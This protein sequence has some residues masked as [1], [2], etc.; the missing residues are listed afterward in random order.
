MNNPTPPLIN[1]DIT[2]DSVYAS[3][4]SIGQTIGPYTDWKL[5]VRACDQGVFFPPPL[6]GLTI[7]DGVNIEEG[8]RVLLTDS[9][10]G[11]SGIWT[12]STGLWQLTNDCP[13]GSIATGYSIYVLEGVSNGKKIFYCV[14]PGGVVG[15]DSLEFLSITTNEFID[16]LPSS[17]IYIGNASNK[18]TPQT[19]SGDATLSNTGVLTLAN[20][21]V[22]AGI[23]EPATLTINSK[24]LVTNGLSSIGGSN[25]NV[26]FNNS[27]ALGGNSN[28]TFDGTNVT[29][30][31]ALTSG[32]IFNGNYLQLS[33]TYNLDVPTT[34]QSL[35]PTGTIT[36]SQG[37]L[38]FTNAANVLLPQVSYAVQVT[39]SLNITARN[40]IFKI[41]YRDTYDGMPEVYVLNYVSAGVSST[42]INLMFINNDTTNNCTGVIRVAFLL[43]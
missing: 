25:G 32:G 33:S 34:I 30:F 23:Y 15:L 24:G 29:I 35:T 1:S 6:I 39:F 19:V 27:G 26:Q 42:V 16:Y 11:N 28:F 8:D 43:C 41:I 9:P 2:L 14:T 4:V 36:N 40:P 7:V 31:G 17:Q 18:A 12:A 38:T 37:T 20:T 13:L 21:G 10:Y 22:V 3:L 5:P